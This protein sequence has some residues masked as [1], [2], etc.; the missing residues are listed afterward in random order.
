MRNAAT[1]QVGTMHYPSGF[2]ALYT[3]TSRGYLNQIK[4]NASGT[5]LFTAQARDADL[6]LT[7]SLA[8]NGVT[9]TN[10]YWDQTGLLRYVR[11]GTSDNIANFNYRYDSLGNLTYRS[12]GY[13][14]VYE[15]FC[16]DPLNRLTKAALA[17]AA[18]PGTSCTTPGGTVKS[19]AY[20]AI[21][22]IV[23]KTGVGT[24]SY[25]AGT[26]PHAIN[27]ITGTVNG[28][29][30][31][32]FTYDLNGNMTAGAGRSVGYTAF[33]MTLS[34]TQGDNEEEYIYDAEHNRVELYDYQ[35]ESAN[36]LYLNDPANGA[37]SEISWVDYTWHDYLKVDGKLI[38]ERFCPV[39]T[40]CSST[41]A[42]RY[43]VTDSLGSVATVTDSTA[44]PDAAHTERDAYDPWGKKRSPVTG[45]DDNSCYSASIST[46]GY[47]SHEHMNGVCLINENARVY[48]PLLGRFMAPDDVIA[49][50]YDGQGLNRYT[51]VDNRP[52]TLTDPT[53]HVMV[54]DD[55]AVGGAVVACTGPQALACAGV[56]AVAVVVIGGGIL[57]YEYCGQLF[58]NE[59]SDSHE[60]KPSPEN[61]GDNQS[62]NRQQNSGPPDPAKSSPP[63]GGNNGSNVH[64][65]STASVRPQARYEIFER[66]NGNVVKTGIS[67]RPIQQNGTLA[68]ANGQ[69][70]TLN[71]AAGTTKYDARIVERNIPNRAQA[72]RSEEQATDRL[73]SE[74]NSL[75][76]QLRPRPKPME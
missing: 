50:I 10:T 35:G 2:T 29:T 19:V 69:V 17:L 27:S 36:V 51:Y 49:D 52:M 43:F 73:H 34:V 28:V 32:H 25:N 48:D 18:D 11:A 23:S 46:R 26:R 33:N 44:L 39:G 22:N 7:Q 38:A 42:W 31:P 63:P 68:R 40:T 67:G 13:S 60:S 45:A 53:G 65:N 37:M 64:G 58:H 70:N 1:G 9:T 41:T 6:H 14:G 47:T 57:C 4:D 54:W 12:D 5:V 16:Y 21:G 8:G 3:Y 72:L 75:E 24:Y 55:V 61:S 59:P 30:N 15:R 71:R 62:N 66:Q 74:G 56:A 20:D 76:L